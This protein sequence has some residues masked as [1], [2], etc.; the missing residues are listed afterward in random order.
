MKKRRRGLQFES[1]VSWFVLV[2]ILDIVMTGL[3]LR[4]SAEGRT[5][6]PIIESNPVAHWVLARWGIQGLAIFKLAMTAVVVTIAEIVG[7]TRPQVA[8]GLLGGGI[9]VVSGVV[10]YTIRLLLLHR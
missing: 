1:E 4:F 3:A 2:S 8:R 10:I 5:T 9:L 6:S 7:R